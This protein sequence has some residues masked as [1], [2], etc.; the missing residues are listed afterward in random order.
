MT[1]LEVVVMPDFFVDRVVSFPGTMAKL[2]R[3]LLRVAKQG[4]GNIPL[5]KQLMLRGGN[6]ANTGAALA[7][8]GARVHLIARTSELGL[9]LLKILLGRGVDLSRVKTGGKLALTVALEASHKG[10]RVNVML[11]DP[12]SVAEFGPEDLSRE[13]LELVRRASFACVFNWN[14]NRLGTQLA[15]KVFKLAR[16]VRFLDTGDPSPK[17]GEIG[18]LLDRVLLKGLVDVLSVN[19]NEALWYASHFE[20][21]LRRKGLE[22]VREAARVLHENFGCTVDLHTPSFSL[23]WVKGEEHRAPAYEVEVKI[24]TGAGDA[25]NAAD[26]F[27]HGL[28]FSPERRLRFAN[29]FAALYVSSGEHPSRGEVEKF[30]GVKG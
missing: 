15:E 25:W 22:A 8:L 21:K 4:G 18:E 6:A 12:G 26:I 23:S 19:E 13:D 2:S 11:G 10:R 27:A 16:G 3:E 20:P 24:S 7:K 29:A 17:R 14:L 9:K 5:T 28:N 1:K 30:I